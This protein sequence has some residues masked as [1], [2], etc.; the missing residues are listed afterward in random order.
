MIITVTNKANPQRLAIFTWNDELTDC[1]FRA[2]EVSD[3]ELDLMTESNAHEGAGQEIENEWTIEI[4][5]K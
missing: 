1:D 5:W 2:F 4:E 3:E